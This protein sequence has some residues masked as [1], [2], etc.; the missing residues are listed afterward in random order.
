MA[1]AARGLV[2]GCCRFAA[3]DCDDLFNTSARLVRRLLTASQN[4]MHAAF[5]HSLYNAYHSLVFSQLRCVTYYCVTV[6]V[7]LFIS[8]IH[9]SVTSRYPHLLDQFES[10]CLLCIQIPLLLTY[11]NQIIAAKFKPFHLQLPISSRH[12]REN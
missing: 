1:L 3:A 11:R 8:H 6:T 7:I 5:T 2:V 10:C 12:S 4:N 9:L